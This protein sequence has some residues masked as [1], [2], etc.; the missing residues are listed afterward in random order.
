MKTLVAIPLFIFWANTAY[1]LVIVG[2]F[3]PTATITAP[4]ANV[5]V[6]LNQQVPFSGYGTSVTCNFQ[7]CPPPPPVT[8]YEWREGACATG[9]LLSTASSFNLTTPTPGVRTIYFRAYSSYGWSPNCPSRIVTVTAI[10]TVNVSSNISSSWTI[11]GP[12]TISGSGT[13]QSSPSKPAGTY[14]ITWGS[15]SGYA[16]PASQSL[17]LSS[18]GTI[19]FNGSYTAFTCANGAVNYPTCT[20]NAGGQCINSTVNPSTCNTCAAGFTF[21]NN[22]C[23]AC[24]N[25]AVNYPTCTTNAGGQ[26]INGASNPAICSTCPSGQSFNTSGVCVATTSGTCSTNADCTGGQIC[27]TTSHTCVDK[28]KTKFWQF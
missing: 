8:A 12:A 2:S 26:C 19:T 28:P 18:G 9:A 24:I 13:S 23:Y 4:S 11:T 20:T 3:P 17:S 6:P 1:A 16:T 22:F 15:V 14:T 21:Y 7:G 25:G 27:N 5:S 10:G